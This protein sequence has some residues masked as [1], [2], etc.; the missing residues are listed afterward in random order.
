MHVA[1]ELCHKLAPVP[2]LF[3]LAAENITAMFALAM[4]VRTAGM[5]HSHQLLHVRAACCMIGKQHGHCQSVGYPHCCLLC[6]LQDCL[7]M[8]AIFAAT[9][10]VATL[11]ASAGDCPAAVL[12]VNGWQ[13]RLLS[14]CYHH[15]CQTSNMIV[16]H[17]SN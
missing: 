13:Q 12:P 17:S 10:S 6:C 14:P 3:G 9:D 5:P 4:H 8:G 15:H 7:A 11:Q 16:L 1:V 2:A